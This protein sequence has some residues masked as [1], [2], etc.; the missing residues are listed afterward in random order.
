MEKLP[1]LDFEFY[2]QNPPQREPSLSSIV[3]SSISKPP[4]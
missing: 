1:W 2:C 3:S 4:R